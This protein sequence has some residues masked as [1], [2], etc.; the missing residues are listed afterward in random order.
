VCVGGNAV[1]VMEEAV[2]RFLCEDW[3]M[4]MWVVL[5]ERRDRYS[6]LALL[7]VRWDSRLVKT[8]GGG[9]GWNEGRWRVCWEC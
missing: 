7:M 6:S 8:V 4:D 5:W 2:L 3:E 9:C 1:V